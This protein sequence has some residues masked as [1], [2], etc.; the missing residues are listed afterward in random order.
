MY[1]FLNDY[2]DIARPEIIEALV[3]AKDEYNVG[4]GFDNHSENAR[5]LIKKALK[6]ENIDIHFVPGGT[7]ANVLGVACGMKQ[8]NSVI[9]ATSGHIQDHEA[10]SIEATGIK[11]ETIKTPTG[12]L[13]RKL[14]EEKLANFNSELVTVP[15]KV[16]ISNT[17]ELGEVYTKK[18][19][20]DIYN[21][22]KENNLYLFIDGA[23]LAA[24]LASEKCDYDI[25][26]FCKLCDV[27]YLGGTKN[28]NGYLKIK[29]VD[30]TV[31]GLI[32]RSGYTVF[33]NYE[34]NSKYMKYTGVQFSNDGL[35]PV[36]VEKFFDNTVDTEITE[37]ELWSIDW[38]DGLSIDASY[39][40][41]DELNCYGGNLIPDML[42][43]S[44]VFTVKKAL[45]TGD[46]FYAEFQKELSCRGGIRI[47]DYPTVTTGY[48]AYIDIN[49]YKLGKYSSSSE[50]YK[51]LGGSLSEEF[52]E[53][54]YNIEPIMARY[55]DGYLE[56]HDERVGVYFPMFRA[57]DVNMYFHLAV[58][59]IDG[60]AENWNERIM[61]PAMFAMI[62]AQKKKIDQ[63]EKLINKLCEKLNIE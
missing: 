38:S 22:C 50:R 29:D 8:E 11:I 51:I 1:F 62:K 2:N 36:N 41:F 24:A 52:I 40:S 28:G 31:K 59:H 34:E 48:N 63:Q 32:D 15:K 26:E 49:S 57:E 42:K 17:T 20:E 55:I 4:Y 25:S 19:L 9:A 18:E 56:E 58:D 54:L 27:F 12:K 6:N 37:L 45:A 61:I 60:K 14:L 39:G 13:T 46:F 33:T 7:P 21:F 5:N 44:D 30:N 3:K 43:I 10:G 47:Y 16:Y 53:N 23:R 35:F